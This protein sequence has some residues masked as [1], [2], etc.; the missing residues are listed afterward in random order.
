M[1]DLPTISV[2]TP[3]FN[4]A[5][6]LEQTI[7]SVLDQ[8][9]PRLEYIV[10][11]GG[12]TDGSADIIRRYAHRLSHWV[13]EPDRGQTHAINKGM[14]R[15][16]GEI[17]AYLNS[18]DLYLPGT[19]NQ[20]AK[21]YRENPGADLFHGSCRVI[22][23]NGCKIAERCGS[24]S[25]FEEI[26]DLWDVWWKRRNFVQ[27]EV[28]WTR[29]IGERI[30]PLREDLYF[31]M[32][33]EYWT[34]MLMVGAKVQKIESELACFRLTCSQKSNLRDGC[35]REI[36]SVAKDY[37]W[38]DAVRFNWLLRWKLQGAWLYQTKFLP[39]VIVSLSHGETRPRR[40]CRMAGVIMK[41]PKAV[42]SRGLAQRSALVVQ[43]LLTGL[44]GE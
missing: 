34:R 21:A 41:H 4:Q 9:Y 24:I 36:L 26:V 20:V 2:V 12:S 28:F 44:R 10:I 17:R 6:Y 42:F 38:N 33:Y 27:P 8:D 18:D 5:A 11:D 13:S 43:G 40:W 39:A 22:D 32:D 3:S 29:R 37:L 25:T 7:R 31:V 23:E 19:L 1:N 30:G 35:A 15:A 16:T 14:E